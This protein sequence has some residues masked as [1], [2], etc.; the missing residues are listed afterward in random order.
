MAKITHK[1]CVESYF[2]PPYADIK[3]NFS[4]PTVFKLMH[5]VM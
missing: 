5:K 1:V 2:A 3:A 4:L